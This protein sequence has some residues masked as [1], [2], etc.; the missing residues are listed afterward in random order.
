MELKCLLNEIHGNMNEIIK[1]FYAN[2]ENLCSLY[3][4][5]DSHCTTEML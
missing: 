5:S 2:L 1:V 4:P 3:F